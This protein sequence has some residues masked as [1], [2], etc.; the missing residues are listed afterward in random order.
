M[1]LLIY[2][3]F[4]PKQLDKYG[5]TPLHLACINGN[6]VA[7]KELVERVIRI[8]VFC[9]ER[10]WYRDWAK[11]DARVCVPN[12][13]KLL[14]NYFVQRRNFSFNIPQF[15]AKSSQ[16]N[17]S[18]IPV[19]FSRNILHVCTSSTLKQGFWNPKW[20]RLP[21]GNPSLYERLPRKE[22]GCPQHPSVNKFHCFF[23]NFSM[24]IQEGQVNNKSVA[25]LIAAIHIFW[26]FHSC[27]WWCGL[28]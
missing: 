14:Q 6:L 11:G 22:W 25:Y 26:I 16:S 21:M 5:Q 28:F 3:G 12:I 23:S 20:L 7:V 15:S 18:I 8:F 1:R 27:R 13:D 2:S 4:N 19:Y 9:P 17:L 10:S 24:A